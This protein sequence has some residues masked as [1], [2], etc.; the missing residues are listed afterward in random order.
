MMIDCLIF[1]VLGPLLITAFG[2]FSG[3]LFLFVEEDVVHQK[4]DLRYEN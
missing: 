1:D 3:G 4:K 2:L